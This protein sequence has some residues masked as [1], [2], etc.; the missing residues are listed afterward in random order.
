MSTSFG[1]TNASFSRGW[2]Q[3]K[4]S[5]L[6]C[7]ILMLALVVSA[8]LDELP[9]GDVNVMVV[10]DVHSW[11]GGH[12]HESEHNADYGDVLSFYEHLKAYSQ[13]H[14]YDLWFVNNGD[15]LHGTGT[16]VT[17]GRQKYFGDSLG[18]FLPTGLTLSRSL[19]SHTHKHTHTFV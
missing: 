19:F 6:G 17:G 18:H 1:A 13:K 9:W 3:Q 15:W 16:W 10:T 7:C 4:L 8:S 2:I 5:F 12:I 14:G 11:I